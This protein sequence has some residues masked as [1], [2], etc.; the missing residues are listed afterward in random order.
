MDVTNITFFRIFCA[1]LYC[2]SS[3]VLNS[4]TT[5]AKMKIDFLI[6]I[7]TLELAKDFLKRC[8]MS[9][10]TKNKNELLH[11][12]RILKYRKTN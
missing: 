8:R 3:A 10:K 5:L 4:A 1:N 7:C 9:D 6:D 2:N 11:Y 12:N